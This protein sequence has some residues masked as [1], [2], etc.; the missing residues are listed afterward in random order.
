MAQELKTNSRLRLVFDAGI[1]NDGHT[2]Y[3]SKTFNNIRKDATA[4]QLS[5]AANA[6]GSLSEFSLLTI[7]KTDQFE[8]V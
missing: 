4:D 7:E 2:I 3:K 5:L 8:I 1:D 6:L